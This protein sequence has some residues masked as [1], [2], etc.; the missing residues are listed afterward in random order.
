MK[1][2]FAFVDGKRRKAEPGL[3]GECCVCG[4]AMIAKCGE[5]R[6][7]VWHWA[8]LRT[9]T[10]DPW[11]E[12]QTDWHRTWKNHFPEAWQEIVHQS[13]TG[14]RHIA[15]VKTESGVVLEFQHSFLRREEREAREM[16]YQN[17]LWVVD[18]LTRVRDKKRFFASLTRDHSI[19]NEKPLT[20]SVQPNEGALLRDWGDS[21]KPVFFDFGD[22]NVFDLLHFGMPLLWRLH[23]HSPDGKALL[24]PVTKTSFRDRCLKR[25]PLKAI[26]Y[27]SEVRPRAIGLIDLEDAW[28]KRASVTWRQLV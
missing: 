2:E 26:D 20:Y 8:H 14:E 1:Y 10:C 5:R 22:N 19:I 11:W 7:R 28:L 18:G 24:S 13:E 23:P 21:C 12:S 17:M 16:F 25:L 3:R 4:D 9:R 15:D 27:S 6:L